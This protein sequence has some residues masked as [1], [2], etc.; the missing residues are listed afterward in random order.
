MSTQS[1][2]GLLDEAVSAIRRVHAQRPTIGVVLG[3]GLGAFGDTL[4][5]ASR[6]GYQDIPNMPMSRVVGHAG[7]LSLGRV[8]NVPVACMQGRVHLY[9][10]HE[11][12]RVVFGVRMLARLGCEAVLITNAAGGVHPSLLAGDLMLIIDHINM[13]GRNPLVGPNIDEF[14]TRFPDMTEAYDRGLC[15]V[16]RKAARIEGISLHEGVYQ[17][18]LGPTY[19]TPAEIR[20][21]RTLGADAVG[22]STVPEVIALRHMQVRT[23]AISCITNLAAGISSHPLDHKEVEQVANRTRADFVRLIRRFVILSAQEIAS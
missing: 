19:E 13:T 2:T 11:P 3:S 6:I 21:A 12:E 17:A 23:A 4:E 10:G 7:V 18:N 22:M 14:G 8:E 20:M 15:E 16:A 9:E 1:I 5:D